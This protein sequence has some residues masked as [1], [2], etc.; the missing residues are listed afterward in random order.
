MSEMPASVAI[1]ED[2]HSVSLAE[3][4]AKEMAAFESRMSDPRAGLATGFSLLDVLIRGLHPGD[5]IIVGGRPSMGKT[6]FLLSV[7]ERM[8]ESDGVPAGFFSME[9]GAGTLAWRFLAPRTRTLRTRMLRKH[10]WTGKASQGDLADLQ[11]ALDSL[12]SLPIHIDDTPVL[13]MQEIADRARAMVEKHRIKI[14]FV[15]SLLFIATEGV[16]EHRDEMKKVLKAL[17]ELARELDIPVVCS[18]PIRRADQEDIAGAFF[19]RL[20]DLRVGDAARIADVVLLVH[21]EEECHQGSKKWLAAHPEMRGQAEVFVAKN[22]RGPTAG[23]EMRWDE[24]GG[25]FYL[26]G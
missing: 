16:P 8:A 5:L 9:L 26:G 7:A 15:D 11:R 10:F 17:K 21:R 4:L 6:S 20:K 24:R 25:R 22:R 19:P 12:R 13:S 14:L 1:L 3:F 2:G 23:V 18:A